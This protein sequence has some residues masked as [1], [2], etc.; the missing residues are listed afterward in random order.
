MLK[1]IS[2]FYI[3]G[4]RGLDVC[5]VIYEKGGPGKC[6]ECDERERG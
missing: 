4:C 3:T 6:D 5:E 2:L 1:V